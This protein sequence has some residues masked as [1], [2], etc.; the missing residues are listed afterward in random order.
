M[1]PFRLPL[2]ICDALRQWLE[3]RQWAPGRATAAWGEDVAMRYLQ[4]QKFIIAARNYRPRSGPGEIDLVAWESGTLAF[5]EVKT[6]T[7]DEAGMPDRAVG[8]RKRQ[9]LE[10]AARDYARRANVDIGDARFDVVTVMVGRPPAIELFRDA[11]RPRD[12]FR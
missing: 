1:N 11:F 3:R 2:R 7:S 12:F 8:L 10:R 9:T 5:I 4:E 6:R